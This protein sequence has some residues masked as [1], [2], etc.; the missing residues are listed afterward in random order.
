MCTMALILSE[1]ASI[2]FTNT[3]QPRTP[4][5]RMSNTHFS[6]VSFNCALRILAKVSTKSYI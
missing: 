3:K 1:L 6:E 2:P 5:F 4:P